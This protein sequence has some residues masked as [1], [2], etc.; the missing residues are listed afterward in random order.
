MLFIP[1]MG[2][3]LRHYRA[4]LKPGPGF[5][6]SYVVLCFVFRELRWEVI[7]CFV[8]IDGF[9]VHYIFFHNLFLTLKRHILIFT[10]CSIFRTINVSQRLNIILCIMFKIFASFIITLFARLCVRVGIL[11]FGIFWLPLW[12]LLIT[13]LVSIDYT[14]GSLWLLLWYLLITPL[15][16][17]DYPLW[18]LLITLLVSSD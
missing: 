11:H 2:L 3:T 1:L 8:A 14:F 12:Y 7:V 4:R 5:P 15:V 16:T 13:T 18:Y 10:T 6:T 17:C 9:Y